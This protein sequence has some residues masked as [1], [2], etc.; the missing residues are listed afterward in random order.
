MAPKIRF[1]PRSKT[2]Q[3]NP[4]NTYGMLRAEDPVRRLGNNWIITRCADVKSLLLNENARSIGISE[5]YSKILHDNISKFPQ[6]V[7]ASLDKVLLLQED[8]MHRVHKKEMMPL[9][10]GVYMKELEVIINSVAGEIIESI[11]GDSDVEITMKVARVL[12][13]TILSRWLNLPDDKLGV[14]VE[15]QKYIRPLIESPG[16]LSYD[17]FNQSIDNMHHMSLLCDYIL[18]LDETRESLFYRALLNGYGGSHCEV[19]NNFFSDMINILIASSETN[20]SLTGSLFLELAHDEELQQ[21]LRNN[22][23]K[24]KIAINETMRLHPPVQITRRKATN[25]FTIR[26]KDIS[27]GDILLLCLG[28]ANRDEEVFKYA[29]RFD[30]NRKN[31]TQHVGFSAG[32]HNCLGQQLAIRQMDIMCKAFLAHLPPFRLDRPEEWQ[33][34]NLV[35]RSLKSLHIRFY[36]PE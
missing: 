16:I 35:L 20:E 9:V 22:P 6:Q 26:D 10:T 5:T 7:I 17:E 4:Y 2:F 19:K 1:N 11:K 36:T 28:S 15:S 18:S 30:L 27:A 13:S 23:E 32:V 12:W 29:D 24:I 8:S 14:L 3:N 31:T 25:A 33:T 21:E 34:G